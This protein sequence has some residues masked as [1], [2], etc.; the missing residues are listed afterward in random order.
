MRGRLYEEEVYVIAYSVLGILVYLQQLGIVHRDI[1]P[2][3]ILVD[4]QLNT[5]L[6]DFGFARIGGKE[7][8]FSSMVVGTT[9]FMPPE[10]L[11]NH[12]SFEFDIEKL[13]P[14]SVDAQFARWLRKMVS[15]KFT[16]SRDTCKCDSFWRNPVSG[17]IPGFSRVTLSGLSKHFK[18]LLMTT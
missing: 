16:L 10:Q 4:E 13:L 8:G 12:E 1:K 11:L 17:G 15:P 18:P 14:S 6:V 7:L 9:A 5:Y 2:E 3:N